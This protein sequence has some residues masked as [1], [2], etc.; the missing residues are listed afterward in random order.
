M[1]NARRLKPLAHTEPFWFAPRFQKWAKSDCSALIMVR[2]TFQRRFEIRDFCVNIVQLLQESGTPVL[3]ALKGVEDN[4]H[5]FPSIQILEC[6]VAQALQIN[7]ALRTE[8][9]ISL[10]RARFEDATTEEDWF[11]LLGSV[12]TGMSRL[13]IIIDVELICPTSLGDAGSFS[14]ST[15]FIDLFRKIAEHSVKT[16]V[17]V[18]LV[19]YGSPVFADMPRNQ[20][21]DL[22][23][24]LRRSQIKPIAV[25]RQSPARNAR[26]LNQIRGRGR[27]RIPGLAG[28]V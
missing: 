3:W 1:R 13:F 7:S 14:S 27:G 15:T 23:V 16:V 9:S 25:Q 18:V 2:G 11:D 17:K 4:A 21:R 6:L 12:L 20:D 5:K 19:T 26:S 28:I 24:S 22:V 10:N 8:H